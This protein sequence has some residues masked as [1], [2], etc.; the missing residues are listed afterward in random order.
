MYALIEKTDQASHSGIFVFAFVSAQIKIVCGIQ[1]IFIYEGGFQKENKNCRKSFG[2][3]TGMYFFVPKLA[4]DHPCC[5]GTS[6]RD[7]C[8]PC[9]PGTT[10]NPVNGSKPSAADGKVEERH[11]R[12]SLPIE[13]S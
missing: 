6:P 4:K 12:R 7:D 2:D 9:K 8:V 3:H 13:I 11:H 5:Q 1:N 10:G